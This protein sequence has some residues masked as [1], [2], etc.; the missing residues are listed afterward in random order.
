MKKDLAPSQ[1]LPSNVDLQKTNSII[2]CIPFLILLFISCAVYFNAL[3]DGFVHD[4]TAQIIENPWIR[5]VDNIPKIFTRNVWGFRGG[6]AN[7]YRPLMHL[8]Y[9]L[10]YHLFGLHPWGFHLVNV[11][12]HSGVSILVFLV[13]RRLLQGAAI[14]KPLVYFSPPFIAALLFAVHPIHTEA[15]TWI[16]GLPDLAMAFFFLLAFYF[17]IIFRAG[18]KKGYLLSIFSF[19][20]AALFKEPALTLPVVLIAYDFLFKKT[21]KD[22][23]AVIKVYSPYAVVSGLYLAVR[24]YVLRG[25]VPQESY[26]YLNT[27]QLVINILPLF[28]EYLASLFWPINLNFWHTFH[29][30]DSLVGEEG[31][32]SILVILIFL[33]VAM[34]S[35]RRN[36]VILFGLLL[37]V[38]PL[39]PTFY[40]KGIPGKPFAERYLYL[41]SVGFVLLPAVFLS[42]VGEKLPRLVWSSVIV[43]MTV[44]GLYAVGTIERNNVWADNSSLWSDTV[45]KAPDSAEAHNNLGLVYASQ[46]KLDRAIAEYQAALRL[47][48]DYLHAHYNLGIAYASQGRLDRAIAEYQA[49]LRLMPDYAEAH[50]NLGIAYASQGR[51]DRAIAEYQAVLQLKP[52][53]AEAHNNLGIA[54]ASQGKLDLA[55]PEF[56]IALR[57]NPDSAEAHNNLGTAYASQGKLDLAIPEYQAALRLKPDYNEAR[58]RLNDIVSRR[59]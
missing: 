35:Y 54:Y 16:A 52:D 45:R 26:T 31:I 59:H 6:I 23:L 57:L 20:A 21:D 12:F 18:S 2:K 3:F 36:K 34:V 10:N 7:Y 37:V 33:S 11:L 13:V 56:R 22:I 27:Y 53:S 4:D 42:W 17:Y 24:Y 47:M 15:V 9:M 8:V 32:R 46:G 51:L 58:Q 1:K 44:A 14:S 40:I 48:P 39:L 29:P 38:V 30:I 28:R 50:N 25:F 49:A 41:P 55:I 19:L 43:F 5:N